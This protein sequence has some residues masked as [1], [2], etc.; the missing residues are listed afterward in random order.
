MINW[1]EQERLAEE[2]LTRLFPICRSI[3]GNGLRES[4]AI[5]QE[6]T[7][8]NLVEYPSGTQCFDWQIPDEW[9]I[10]DA[11]IKD[12]SGREIVSFRKNNLHV[13]GYS[14]PFHKRLSFDELRPHLHSLPS[15]PDAIPY[16]T[17]YYSRNWGFCLTDRQL[18]Q[19]DQSDT[20]EVFID[21]TLAP[22]SLS[23]LESI[24]GPPESN[25][26]LVSTYCCHP[27]MANDNLSGVV[28]TTLLHRLMNQ[29]LKL[30]KSYRF[31]ILPE[32]IGAIAYLA[33]HESIMRQSS[34]GFVVTTCAGPGP[35]GFKTTFQG[36]HLIDRVIR[37]TMREYTVEPVEYPFA[38]DGSDER[39]YSSPGF[40]IPV[41]SITRDKYYEYSF[42][43][44]SLDDLS[45]VT[46]QNLVSTLRLY[47]SCIQ[48]LEKE[49]TFRSLNPNGEVQLGRR[50]LYPQTGGALKQSAAGEGD[51]IEDGTSDVL[52]PRQADPVDAITWFLFLAD[53]EHSLLSMAERSGVPFDQL[54]SIALELEKQ[55]LCSAN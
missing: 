18:G 46:P 42:Y 40:R 25:E 51:K 14:E 27:S 29:S 23:L 7:E 35:F 10:S 47:W 21:A 43:H 55:G 39:Q 30:N 15:L 5:I 2:L 26:Y 44:T 53:G 13:M 33:H 28:L 19:L 16:R 22:G 32:T 12:S 4:L 9:N 6:Y 38:P 1:D 11:W 34:G 8:F 52:T 48:K 37:Q 17:S 31:L 45:F 3:T 49:S 20:F 41:A 24:I 54:Y 36:N 50:G